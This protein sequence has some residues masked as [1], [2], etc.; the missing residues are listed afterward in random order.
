M[1]NIE[2][3]PEQQVDQSLKRNDPHSVRELLTQYPG[4]FG[5]NRKFMMNALLEDSFSLDSP[6]MIDTLVEFGADINGPSGF[7]VDLVKSATKEIVDAGQRVISADTWV[8]FSMDS[9]VCEA[10]CRG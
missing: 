2:T 3:S 5:N 7:T 4:M 1:S 10:G 8:S 9:G 6:E